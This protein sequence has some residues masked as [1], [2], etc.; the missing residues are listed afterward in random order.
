MKVVEERDIVLCNINMLD[1]PR[2]LVDLQK[3]GAIIGNVV[4][5]FKRPITKSAKEA[6]SVEFT[7]GR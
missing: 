6:N 1:Q 7:S 4:A 5:L 2:A 3:I